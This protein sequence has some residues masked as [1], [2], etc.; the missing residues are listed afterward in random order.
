MNGTIIEKLTGRKLVCLI[1]FL[2]LCQIICFLIGGFLASKST[3]VEIILGTPCQDI[4]TNK[5]D[6]SR[7]F[8]SRG[9]S[10][11]T[12]LKHYELNYNYSDIVFTFQLPVPRYGSEYHVYSRWQQNLVAALQFDTNY[13]RQMEVYPWNIVNLDA[14]LAYRNE[15]DEDSDWKLY[16]KSVEQRKLNCV[17][18]VNAK[19]PTVNICKPILLFELGSLFH[20]YYLLNL[21]LSPDGV[22]LLKMNASISQNDIWLILI[23]QN[24]I[25][26]KVCISFK[27]VFFPCIIL[28]MAWFWRRVYRIK[29]ELF[30]LEKMLLSLA[31]SLCLL[32]MPLE[33]L[34]LQFILPFMLLIN[35]IRQGLFGVKLLSFWLIFFGENMI[36]Q[37]V[38]PQIYLKQ[39]W[40][41]LSAVALG[42]TSSLFFNIYKRCLPLKNPF[43]SIWATD[44]GTNIAL[45]FIILA[46][47]LSVI[48]FLFLCY[49]VLKV[50][51]KTFYK[52]TTMFSISSLQHEI[53]ISRKPRIFQ[54]GARYGCMI[55]II[56]VSLLCAALT[57]IAFI[58]N[59][60]AEIQWKWNENL[61]LNY[62]S[63]LFIGVYGM[64]NIY[65]LTLLILYAP[66]Q[67]YWRIKQNIITTV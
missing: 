53:S 63:A 62:T 5:K 34:A 2:L 22:D 59:L 17:K 43:D 39:Y 19:K 61:E 16:T 12:S 29:R 35:D 46:S 64:L 26:T 56:V 47:I 50:L 40:R 60:V 4:S 28:I 1:F 21:R 10:A 30:L 67:K 57:L 7:W 55:F 45:I 37:K 13:P 18:D 25:F 6:I 9:T 44:S 51:K 31:T 33:F 20:N 38:S 58:T 66:S 27:T 24:E 48:Y 42:C 41:H 14:Q 3:K 23:Y 11:C 52:R 15:G 54:P 36:I 8:Y 32:N 65:V 49:M